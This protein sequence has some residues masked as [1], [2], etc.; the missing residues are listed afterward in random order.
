MFRA[1]KKLSKRFTHLDQ[2]GPTE[3]GSSSMSNGGKDGI[4]D[5][6]LNTTLRDTPESNLVFTYKT[7][8]LSQSNT[9]S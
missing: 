8:N 6:I 4:D 9:R 7:E 2:R 1:A 5:A 3:K